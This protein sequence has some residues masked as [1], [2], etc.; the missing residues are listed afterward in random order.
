MVVGFN[1]SDE[2]DASVNMLGARLQSG[3]TE[4]TVGSL[5][6]GAT[7]DLNVALVSRSLKH[8]KT[9]CAICSTSRYF[10]SRKIKFDE[11]VRDMCERCEFVKEV[12]EG[13]IAAGGFSRS[14]T[15]GHEIRWEVHQERSVD[16]LR[17][18]D[19]EF[20]NYRFE[21]FTLPGQFLSYISGLVAKKGC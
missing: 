14:A 11:P 15:R 18:C 13:C 8:V 9:A 5:N 3:M 2:N 6:D 10:K 17:W 20:V 12:V 1:A 21:I 16:D 19:L 4:P 7:G